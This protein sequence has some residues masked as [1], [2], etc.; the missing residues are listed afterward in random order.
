MGLEITL[1]GPPRVERDGR[2]IAFDTRK[3]TA[4]L[5]HLALADRPRSREALAELLWPDR[6]PEH[7]RGALRRTLSTLRTAIGEEWLETSAGRV[8]LSRAKDLEID[9]E[10]FRAL[11]ED[12]GAEAA[13]AEAVELSRGEFMEGFALRDSAEFDHWQ[14]GE[15][16]ALR[17]EL[18]GVLGRLVELLAARGAFPRAITLTRRRLALDPL[19]EPT[20]R[21][22]IRLFA[23]SGDRAAALDAYRDCVRR[24][25][26]E[27][28]VAPLPDTTALYEQVNEG[29]LDPP[30]RGADGMATPAFRIAQPADR[31]RGGV[32]DAPLVGRVEELRA[33]TESYEGIAADGGLAVIEGEAGIG[34]TRLATEFLEAARAR[35]AAVLSARCHEGEARIAYGPVPSCS[36][37]RASAKPIP[38]AGRT[39]PSRSLRAGSPTWRAWPPASS[40]L[41]GL[42]SA[43]A[44][45]TAL[46]RR[47]ACSKASRRCWSPRAG[48]PSPA[49]SSSTASTAPTPPRS[50][51]SSSS[52]GG[53]ATGR[54]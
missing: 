24:L 43:S 41:G 34:K 23:W 26:Q 6:G 18:A 4:L 51:R 7:A 5:A 13:L 29:T 25:S 21:Q 22:L 16:D 50:T 3:A 28:G 8:A 39:G 2:P 46:A 14:A 52:L 45:S 30:P 20:H 10:R 31:A 15:A 49:W 38:P 42:S 36:A 1:L 12:G 32:G 53:S 40:N 37:R 44:L 48:P 17:R 9:V 54:C 33:L 27:L 19:H 47:L 11:S 35:G